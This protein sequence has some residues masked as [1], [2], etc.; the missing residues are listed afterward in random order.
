M[1]FKA[2]TSSTC[3]C[4]RACFENFSNF[5]QFFLCLFYGSSHFAS[6]HFAPNVSWP[7]CEGTHCHCPWGPISGLFCCC[8][9]WAVL[10]SD[11]APFPVPCFP[12]PVSRS[13][14][15]SAPASALTNGLYL[16]LANLCFYLYAPCC[17]SLSRSLSRLLAIWL[18]CR[19]VAFAVCINIQVVVIIAV[20]F[21]FLPLLAHSFAFFFPLLFSTLLL[22]L[23]W[24]WFQL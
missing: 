16:T 7:N 6:P 1:H 12:F 2:W 9:R 18:K 22:L 23:S 24:H 11:S 20:V 14:S 17:R 4:F 8:W 19:M 10:L 3:S 21:V 15:R 13:R 5:K